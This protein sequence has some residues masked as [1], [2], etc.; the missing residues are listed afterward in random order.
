MHSQLAG[1]LKHADGL[2]IREQHAHQGPQAFPGLDRT[3][4]RCILCQFLTE[5]D[6]QRPH[7]E[8]LVQARP[9]QLRG[10][11]GDAA[12]G[13]PEATVVSYG[14]DAKNKYITTYFRNTFVVTN[15]ARYDAL[16][17]DLLR[18]D[19]AV[20]W[21]SQQVPS[22]ETLHIR[23]AGQPLLA[24]WTQ[25]FMSNAAGFVAQFFPI[26]LLGALFGKLMEASF[27]SLS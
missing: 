9:G 21:D 17:L 2:R 12:V 22:D 4:L 7:G 24:N 18:D 6:I 27:A 23:Y 3:M 8:Q 11:V 5:G 1:C 20:V 26:F 15:Q 25:T 14:P 19:G 16:T 13:R 10:Q